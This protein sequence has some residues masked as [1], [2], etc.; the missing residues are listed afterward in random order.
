[1]FAG[2]KEWVN[3]QRGDPHDPEA[4]RK[5][6][7]RLA[8]D[9]DIDVT[10]DGQVRPSRVAAAR[11]NLAQGAYFQRDVITGIVDRLLAQWRI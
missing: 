8:A 2:Q 6:V 9:G 10:A 1:M 5:S 11:R 3:L 7:A 4:L